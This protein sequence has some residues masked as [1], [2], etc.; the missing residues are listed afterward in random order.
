[1]LSTVHV[2]FIILLCIITIVCIFFSYDHFHSNN[3]FPVSYRSFQQGTLVV[4]NCNN[5][6]ISNSLF[7]ANGI[8]VATRN[9]SEGGSGGLSIQYTNKVTF[10]Q[11]P[12]F[13]ISNCSFN[14]NGALV[15]DNQTGIFSEVDQ[16]ESVYT[17]RGGAIFMLMQN[18]QRVIGLIRNSMF[19]NNRAG[20]YGGA[21]YIAFNSLSR[22]NI[23]I[24]NSIFHRNS[25]GLAGGGI[26]MSFQEGGDDDNV[27]S[28]TMYNCVMRNNE[29]PYGGGVYFLISIQSGL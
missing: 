21:I 26:M 12:T 25:A 27:N 16:E 17:G 14:T 24:E 15:D 10:P 20:F 11:P 28:V 13:L 9:T 23:T 19:I 29:A 5:V 18:T 6:V 8:K 22:N 7:R 1:M 3:S 2:L 4:R